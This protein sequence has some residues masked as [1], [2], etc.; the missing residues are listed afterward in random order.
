MKQ[1]TPETKDI[2]RGAFVKVQSYNQ[3]MWLSLAASLFEVMGAEP[4]N[5]DYSLSDERKFVS[6]YAGT[7]IP[8][9]YNYVQW[10]PLCG[11][12]EFFYEAPA[13]KTKQVSML[14]LM[15]AANQKMENELL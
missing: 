1:S 13:P 12:V 4:H 2:K 7:A 10:E 6:W 15:D 11:G 5:D 3:E 9:S 14:E 8:E